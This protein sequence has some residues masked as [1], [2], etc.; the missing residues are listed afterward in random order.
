M[1]RAQLLVDR[2]KRSPSSHSETQKVVKNFDRLSDMLC[3]VIDAAEL[4][5]HSHPQRVWVDAAHEV[6]ESMCSFMNTLNTDFDLYEVRM[7]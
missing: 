4:V 3:G 1:N 5:R 7:L 2:I 6:Y